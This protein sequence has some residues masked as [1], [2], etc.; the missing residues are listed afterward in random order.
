MH[1]VADLALSHAH[2]GNGFGRVDGAAAAKGDE[3]IALFTAINFQAAFYDFVCR[4]RVGSR[5]NYIR[6]ICSFQSGFHLG[7]IAK[8]YHKFI[9]HNKRFG[10]LA[11]NV[12][13]QIR[14]DILA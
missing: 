14:D 2:E 8:L 13:A 5:I 10:S 4:F 1:V 11:P 3:K 7:H 6:N 12:A 9:C